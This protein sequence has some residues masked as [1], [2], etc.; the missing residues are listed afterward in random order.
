M[1]PIEDFLDERDANDRYLHAA[2]RII[3]NRE[4]DFPLQ[5]AK[6]KKMA[7]KERFNTLKT[8]MRT[9]ASRPIELDGNPFEGVVLTESKGKQVFKFIL[10]KDC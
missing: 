10:P 4:D 8:I 2:V 1:S 7:R 6:S 3:W 9:K 5:P